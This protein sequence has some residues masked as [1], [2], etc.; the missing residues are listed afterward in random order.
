MKRSLRMNDS[1]DYVVL[2]TVYVSTTNRTPTNHGTGVP[3]L[4]CFRTLNPV[5]TLCKKLLI[6]E[7]ILV[8]CL[9]IHEH[10]WL[11]SHCSY[12]TSIRNQRTSNHVLKI[13][14]MVFSGVNLFH[15]IITRK[16][17]V[18]RPRKNMQLWRIWTRWIGAW[19][20]ICIFNETVLI[21]HHE[22]ED[23]RVRSSQH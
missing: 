13:S 21:F 14:N 6:L 15:K 22:L 18:S 9:H 12:L 3:D 4:H 20:D 23:L 19:S 17:I 11:R 7:S 16:I 5:E 1:T 8:Y 2:F 10:S